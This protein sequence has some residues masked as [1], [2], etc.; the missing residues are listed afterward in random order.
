M[1]AA[2]LDPLGFVATDYATLV[3]GLKPVTDPAP[4]LA[5]KGLRD[6]LD[7]WLAGNAV[8]KRTFRTAAT[9]ALLIERNLPQAKKSGRQAIISSDILYDT[10][11][12]Y[13]PDHLMLRITREEALRGLVD[14]G[15]IEDMLERTAGRIDHVTLDRIPPL[16]APMLLEMGRSPDPNAKSTL[17]PPRNPPIRR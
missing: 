17:T 16:A 2:G 11:L 15:R 6:G 9:I 3:W 8:M 4:L 12:K 14:F 1:E 13:D 10:L 5:A 7:H